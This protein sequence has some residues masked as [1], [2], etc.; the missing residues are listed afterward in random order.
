[1]LPTRLSR[2]VKTTTRK[3]SNQ[4]KIQKETDMKKLLVVLMALFTVL[5]ASAKCDFSKVRVQ[6]WNQGV[7]YKWYTSG[8]EV[9]SCKSMTY[10]LFDYQTQK[11]DTL[12]SFRGIVEIAFNAPGTYKLYIKL[13]DRCNKCDTAMYRIVEIQ[14]WYPKA[15]YSEKFITCDS[16]V[17]EMGMMGGA[18][19][20]CYS[21][22]YTIYHG[23]ELDELTQ[24]D[25][26]SMSDWDLIDYYSFAI[27][28]I[29]YSSSDSRIIRYKFP[30]EG[31]FLMVTQY[32]NKC[33]N[34]DTF[35]LRRYTIDC[36]ST[37]ITTL[38]KQEPKLI[39]M[40]DILGRPVTYIRENELVIYLYSDGTYKKVIKN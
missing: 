28:D 37:G 26:D 35:F 20:T 32:Y 5:T 6:Q 29:H 8:W 11:V 13:S 24:N 22:Y 15:M 23:N 39:G 21:Y 34:Q 31:R 16:L 18:K 19:D 9:D 33:N 4:S 38:T 7:Y 10:L 17:G 14:R 3:C 30:H 40:F 25:W 27:D 12:N 1:M 2:R 36:N